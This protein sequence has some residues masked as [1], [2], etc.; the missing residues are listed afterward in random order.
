M[1]GELTAHEYNS[2][3]AH[4]SYVFLPPAIRFRLLV[5]YSL[6][7]RKDPPCWGD[8]RLGVNHDMSDGLIIQVHDVSKIQRQFSSLSVNKDRHVHELRQWRNGASLPH[9]MTAIDKD[10]L[11]DE[12]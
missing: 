5:N 6:S 11:W 12:G 3:T 10:Y 4:F 7:L 9:R 2:T 8:P 1:S